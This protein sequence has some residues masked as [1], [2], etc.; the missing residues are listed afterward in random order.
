MKTTIESLDIF[1]TQS[2]AERRRKFEFSEWSA[3]CQI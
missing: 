1:P 2:A 3:D